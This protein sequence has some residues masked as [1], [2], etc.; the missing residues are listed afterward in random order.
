MSKSALQLEVGFCREIKC[1]G[2]TRSS[3]RKQCM[4]ILSLNEVESER[5][6]Q[7]SQA[8]RLLTG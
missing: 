7:L 1:S 4:C 8:G 5:I 3:T 6:T 2:K